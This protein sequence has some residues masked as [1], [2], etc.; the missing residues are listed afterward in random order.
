MKPIKIKSLAEADGDYAAAQQL[1][2]RLRTAKSKIDLEEAD[3][4]SKLTNRP[5]APE[6]TNKVAALLGE[7]NDDSGA[8][9]DG[10]RTRLREIAAER[11]DLKAALT[12]ASER[13]TKARHKASKAICDEVRPDYQLRSRRLL[14][15]LLAPP[16][17]MPVY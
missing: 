9:P 6:M 2:S 14:T 7:A 3:L 16:M 11:L 12:I 15:P 10:L 8:V 4:L 1:E 17:P 13:L 5:V